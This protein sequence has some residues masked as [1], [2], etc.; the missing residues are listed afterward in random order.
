MGAD[1]FDAAMRGWVARHRFGFVSQRQLLRH[2]QARTD[3]DLG[4][5]L[6]AYLDDAE[7]ERFSPARTLYRPI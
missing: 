1:A 3:A 7:V 4:P 6:S 2:L 5:I